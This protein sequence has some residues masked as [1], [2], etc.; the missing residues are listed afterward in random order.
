MSIVLDILK[1]LGAM[2][3]GAPRMAA[4]LLALIAIVAAVAHFGDAQIAGGLLLFGGLALLAE[5]VLDTARKSSRP[6]D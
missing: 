2:F 4:P 5:N 3:F 6:R 1:E